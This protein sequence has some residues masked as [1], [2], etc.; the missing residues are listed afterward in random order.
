VNGTNTGTNDSVFTTASLA[1]GALVKVIV[2]PVASC[3]TPLSQP[4]NVITVGVNQSSIPTV[5]TAVSANNICTGTSVNFTATPTNGGTTPAYQWQVNNVNVGTN[6]NTFTSTTLNNNDQV[7][8]ILTSNATCVT[9]PTATS[10]PITMSVNASTK[11]TGKASSPAQV[12]AGTSYNVNFTSTN[13]PNGSSVQIWA[14]TNNGTFASGNTQTYNGSGLSFPI[15]P[16]AGTVKYFFKITPA[17]SNTCMATNNSDTS[18]T[19]VDQ[20]AKPIIAISANSMNVTNA[21]A[22]VSYKWQV[23]NASNWI[24]V[25]TTGLYRVQ[26]NKGLCTEYS[27]AQTITVTNS[28]T[29]SPTEN[30][31]LY[32][33]PTRGSL[34]L[35][36]LKLSDNWEVLDIVSLQS[37]QTVA[38]FN[39]IN[40][41][42]VTVNLTTLSNGIYAAVLKRR[43]G[44]SIS[45]EFVK[46]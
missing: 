35:D 2:T 22:T 25:T 46:M 27:D 12:C 16:S 41:T 20:V 39:I 28:N 33:N 40:Q 42:K 5:A 36:S 11:L 31:L 15:S 8:V 37:G 9:T 29:N 18:T 45:I 13:A 26:A 21:D 38:S 44:S 7:K 17:A 24:D 19:V 4:S 23:Q 30:V 1:N 10:T 14:S 43:D 3:I 34:T 6:S 32:P